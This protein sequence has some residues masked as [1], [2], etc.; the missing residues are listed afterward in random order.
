MQSLQTVKSAFPL[1][2]QV[3]RA[4]LHF[5]T[6]P[7]AP[8]LAAIS[9]LI[10]PP[11]RDRPQR[12]SQPVGQGD[13]QLFMKV[14]RIDTLPKKLRMM[15]GKPK[16]SGRY[17]WPLEE[18]LNTVVAAQRGLKTARVV[19]FGV[20]KPRFGVVE[21]FVL[22]TEM[23]DGYCNGLQWLQKHPHRAVEFVERC[24][25]LILDMQS[26]GLT[27]LDLWVANVMVPDD[28]AR[29]WRVIDMENVFT[30]LSAFPSQTLGWQLGFLYR[31]ELH[32][33]IDEA[34]YDVLVLRFVGGCPGV[35]RE[36]FLGVYRLSKVLALSHKKRRQIFLEGCLGVV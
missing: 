31:R 10:E 36:A 12:V 4:T 8:L 34:L 5:A 24:M 33:F 32:R 20:V 2:H 25:K 11:Y 19:G 18:L 1:R 14:Q 17:D 9:K 13:G 26:R 27:H 22:L 28:G 23:L 15:L 3:A 6:S 7:G 30:R 35:D 29:S 16:R 21:E